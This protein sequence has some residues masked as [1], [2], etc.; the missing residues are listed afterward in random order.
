MVEYIHNELTVENLG[1]ISSL[2]VFPGNNSSPREQMATSQIGQSLLPYGCA[3]RFLQTGDEFQ[4]GTCT[5]NVSIPVD[6]EIIDVV[7]KV[8][9]AVHHGKIKVNPV[10]SVI[11]RDIDKVSVFG[12][13][14][15]ERFHA[16]HQA[17]GIRYKEHKTNMA[18]IRPGMGVERGT[19]LM[20]SPGI[21]ETGAYAYSVNANVAFLSVPGVDNDGIIMGSQL[22]HDFTATGIVSLNAKWGSDKYP[23]NLYGTKDYY[24]PF[25]NIGDK[26]RPDG[27]VMAFREYDLF[28]AVVDMTPEALMEV[29]YTWD[30]CY[31]GKPNGEVLDITVLH[32]NTRPEITPTGM[33]EQARMYFNESQRYYGQLRNTYNELRRKYRNLT[34]TPALQNLLVRAEAE[35]PEQQSNVQKTM[36]KDSLDDW[37][38]YL[39]FAYDV[40][41][42]IGSKLTD[43]HG[44][45]GV[46]VGIWDEQDMPIDEWGTRAGLIMDPESTINRMNLGRIY[47]HGTNWYSARIINRLLYLRETRPTTFYQDAWDELM[48]YYKTVSIRHYRLME[49]HYRNDK[50]IINHVNYVMQFRD[51]IHLHMPPDREDAGYPSYCNLKE[52]YPE[53]KAGP[54]EYRTRKGRWITTKKPVKIASM[55]IILL[56]KTG[57]DWSAVSTPKMQHYG[58]PAMVTNDD[59]YS[60]PGREQAVK[61]PGEAET[62]L[63][64][65]TV[66]GDVTADLVDLPNIPGGQKQIAKTLLLAENPSDVGDILNKEQFPDGSNRALQLNKHVLL[67]SGIT[68]ASEG[69]SCD[70]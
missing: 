69:D 66:G 55:A 2:Q 43:H 64:G 37:H 50:D 68:F 12:V 56:E 42:S 40:I 23:L 19:V 31:Y 44:G 5:F 7:H 26:I 61:L 53:F 16:A 9:T 62:R 46:I 65:S 57:E 17:F 30:T 63:L 22:I 38:V 48:R 27:L 70:K 1:G 59:K 45:K 58:I 11:W 52:T 13:T 8:N 49:H 14:H 36:H 39:T 51:G 32:Q 18:K 34:L 47:E 4:Y 28:S 35:N 3:E 25:P 15:I 10:M 21:S 20:H 54:V 67:C 60:T 29:D 24:Q 6:A 33:S 41:P